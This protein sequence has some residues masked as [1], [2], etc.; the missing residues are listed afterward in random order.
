MNADLAVRDLDLLGERAEMI[1]AVAAAIDP[2]ALV[3]RPANVRTICGVMACCK[4]A[5]SSAPER[6]ASACDWCGSPS[7]S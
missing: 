7:G 3:R 6:A 2:D 1:L 5:S 4:E